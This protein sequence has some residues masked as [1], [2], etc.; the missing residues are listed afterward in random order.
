M[1][2]DEEEGRGSPTPMLEHRSPMGALGDRIARHGGITK[3][4]GAVFVRKG[5][6]RCYCD[7]NGFLFTNF[8]FVLNYQKL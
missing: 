7:W 4:G 2:A 1:K 3:P 6:N 5:N 8:G